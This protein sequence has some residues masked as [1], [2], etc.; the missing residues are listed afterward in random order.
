MHDKNAKANLAKIA[1]IYTFNLKEI[2]EDELLGFPK[3]YLPNPDKVNFIFTISDEPGGNDADYFIGYDDYSPDCDFIYPT[4]GKKRLDIFVNIIKEMFDKTASTRLVI[5]LTDSGY[6][7]STKK[8]KL[9][10]LRKVLHAD[11]K[12]NGASDRLYDITI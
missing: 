3:E 4:E 11:L 9:L 10:D 7:Y 1:E 12:V 2:P 8:V 6:I 5:A